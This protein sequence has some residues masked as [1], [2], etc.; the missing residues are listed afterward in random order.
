MA[1]YRYRAAT[2]TGATQSGTL[3]GASL[4]EVLSEL[5]RK[6]LS[7]IETVETTKLAAARRRKSPTARPG[8]R[9]STRSASWRS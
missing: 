3:E 4:G 5:R 9:R 2:A 8:R 6:G 1:T 7:P